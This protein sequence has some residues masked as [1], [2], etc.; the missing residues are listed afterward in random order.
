MVC[1]DVILMFYLLLG[2]ISCECIGSNDISTSVLII[3]SIE[4]RLFPSSMILLFKRN[5]IE[6][7]LN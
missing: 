4:I 5:Q 3:L 6:L 2:T 7:Q 1:K